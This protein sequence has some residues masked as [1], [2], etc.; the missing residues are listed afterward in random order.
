MSGKTRKDRINK[1]ITR[2]KLCYHL[3]NT[4]EEKPL[5]WFGLVNRIPEQAIVRRSDGYQTTTKGK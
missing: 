4:N 3:M 1:E 5:K 2:D